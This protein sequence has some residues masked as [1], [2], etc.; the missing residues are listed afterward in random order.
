MR[1]KMSFRILGTGR[2]LPSF[3]LKNSDLCAFL[4]TS[5]E[6]ITTRTGIK[7]RHII[8]N[9]NVTSLAAQAAK[10]ALENAC[11]DASELDL[12]ICA[13]ISGEYQTPSLSCLVQKELGASCP[14]FDINAAC[15][16]FIY[17]LDVAAGFFER[18]RV[19]KALVIGIEAMSRFTNWTDRST[20]VLFGDGG[21]A[22]VLGSGDDLLGITLQAKGDA[23][24]LNIPG[25]A[26]NCPYGEKN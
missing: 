14:A 9:E 4:D 8:T 12:I 20:C 7:E 10:N 15:S 13:T 3:I 22:V 25:Q 2:A 1:F 26:G 16:G 6:W 18:K 17:A 23:E 19:K 11:T 24:M 21:G 5:D